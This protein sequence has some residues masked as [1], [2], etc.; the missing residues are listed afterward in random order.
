MPSIVRQRRRR[1]GMP[2]NN[3]QARVAPPAAYQGAPLDLGRAKAAVVAAV[4]VTVKVPVPAEASVM[5]TGVVAPKL[6]VGR[7]VAPAGLVAIAAVRATLP[8]RPPLGVT[9]IVA[10]LPVVAPGELMVMAPLL[11]NAKVGGGTNAVTVTPTA[12]VCVIAPEIPVT[13]TA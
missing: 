7:S 12:V 13:V 9:V 6:K 4:V 11:V 5:L 8:V 1:T 2:M 10:V 3:K